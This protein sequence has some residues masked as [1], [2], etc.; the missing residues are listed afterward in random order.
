MKQLLETI[1]EKENRLILEVTL[2]LLGT[3]DHG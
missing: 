2:E 3:T 1:N